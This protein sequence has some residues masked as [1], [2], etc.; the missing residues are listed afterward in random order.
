VRSATG[1]VTD[2]L[3]AWRAGNT[4]AL[5][6]LTP[7][8]YD[9]LH[10]LAHH[11]LAGER[12]GHTLQATALVNEAYLRLLDC[13]DLDWKDRSHFFAVAAQQMRRILVDF[14]R[15]RSNHRRGGA[16]HHTSL[17]E[18]LCVSERP[19]PDLIALDDALKTL[20]EIDA[21]KSQVVELRF[22]GGLGEREIAEALKISVDTVQ[23]DWKAARVWLYNHL[24][25]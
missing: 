10:R 16:F 7:L 4:G 14:A 8:V 1:N 25:R 22:F 9:H 2:L 23:R 24:R 18:A 13:S 17:D 15:A 19:N 3:L 11:Y 21:R 12:R 6:K 5:H 20:A